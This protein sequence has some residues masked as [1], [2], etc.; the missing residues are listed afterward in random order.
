M[1]LGTQKISTE[2]YHAV[3]REEKENAHEMLLSILVKL[4]NYVINNEFNDELIDELQETKTKF[5]QEV[6]MIVS[7]LND[8]D[9]ELASNNIRM[10]I[11]QLKSSPKTSVSE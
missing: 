11:E 1:T 10:L 5:S 4:E 9:F 6:N 7:A 2:N 3:D 8:F